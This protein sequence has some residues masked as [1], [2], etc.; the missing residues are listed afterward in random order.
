MF[1]SPRNTIKYLEVYSVVSLCDVGESEVLK[2]LGSSNVQCCY[3]CKIDDS[4]REYDLFFMLFFMSNKI[5]DKGC[6]S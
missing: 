5:F 1:I 2:T 4:D 6:V 3:T